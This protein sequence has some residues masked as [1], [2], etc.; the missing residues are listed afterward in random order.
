[1]RRKESTISSIWKR[2]RRSFID[3][4]NISLEAW[5][6]NFSDLR[7]ELSYRRHQLRTDLRLFRNLYARPDTLL[8]NFNTLKH[9]ADTHFMLQ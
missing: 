9:S 7:L 2:A 6:L 4:T 3:S 5:S 1:M 8:R